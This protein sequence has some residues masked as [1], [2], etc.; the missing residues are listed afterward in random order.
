VGLIGTVTAMHGL[1][2][3]GD[4]LD[5]LLAAIALAVA[6]VPE[7]LPAILAVVLALGVQ[8]MAAHRAIVKRLVSV[9]TLGSTTVICT[10]KTGTLTRNEMTV[11]AAATADGSA[12][13]TGI[14][15]APAG[16]L[17]VGTDAPPGLGDRIVDLLRAGAAASNARWDPD[18]DGDPKPVGDPTEVA[19]I[20]AHRKVEPDGGRPDDRLD[21]V[22]FDADRKMMSVL[23][24]PADDDG[25]ASTPAGTPTLLQVTKGAPEM[26][27]ARCSTV[28][29]SGPDGSRVRPLDDVRRGAVTATID[30]WAAEGLRTLA[31][32]TKPHAQ[33][34]APFDEAHEA[35]MTL[36]GVVAIVDPLRA[37]A[38][39][40]VA[41]ARRAGVEVRMITGDHPETA[42]AIA[43]Q[44]GLPT[45]D[46]TTGAQIDAADDAERAQLLGTSSVF[47]RV[48]PEHKLAIV[49]RLRRDGAIVA[50]TGD[51]VNDAPALRSADIGIAMGRTGTDVARDAAD[52][53]L[54]DDDFGTIV[55]AVREGRHIYENI[56]KF[57]R[58]LLATNA[59]E[60]LLMI[61]GVVAA[62]AIGLATVDEAALPLLAT[63]ILWIN[64]VTDAAPALALGVDP[65]VDDVMDRHPRP[66][67][68]PVIDAPM[69]T[70][71]ALIGSV[72]AIAGLAA[73]DLGLRGGV[74]GG[75]GDIDQARTMAF[76][77]VVLAQ[78]FNAFN[79]RSATTTLFT[80]PF[81][82]RLLV[83]SAAAAVL[84]QIV[85]VHATPLNAAFSTTPL[86]AGEWLLCTA[87]G[88]TV[89]LA[90]EAQKLVRRRLNRPDRRVG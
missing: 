76:T 10:D 28:R 56:R 19:L 63:Q 27:L 89:V 84:A 26:I 40:A 35:A 81:G 52:M 59:G 7:G 45:A 88:S 39:D 3:G 12:T 58:Y 73:L 67:D 54:T 14:G 43:A 71:I 36:E 74:L 69:W 13:L 33:P 21:E 41:A 2:S 65:P 22:P 64:L 31:I 42:V 61:G 47:A 6:A 90:S 86:T 11:V 15:F 25:E 46:V 87:L 24:G 29:A 75:T 17:D 60:V 18:D 82:N 8:R 48:T 77:T 57:L 83:V 50:M 68:E 55:D 62:G 70:T 23:L 79:A 78:V 1:D 37:A 49:Q 85:V 44:L 30:R 4:L 72:T 16:E 9:E 20:V 53:V 34:P 80:D 66:P 38:V 51:G 32:A 5:L